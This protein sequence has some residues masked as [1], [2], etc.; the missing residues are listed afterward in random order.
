MDVDEILI[1]TQLSDLM[2]GIRLWEISVGW[3][4]LGYREFC[5]GT[6]EFREDGIR[7]ERL[8]CIAVLAR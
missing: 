2:L 3:R 8:T 5:S 1:C 7:A 4:V 6:V